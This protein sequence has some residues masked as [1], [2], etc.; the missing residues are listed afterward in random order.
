MR[1][2]KYCVIINILFFLI[3]C[4]SALIAFAFSNQQIAYAADDTKA[5]ISVIG[6]IVNQE[7]GEREL[8]IEGSILTATY[9]NGM[10]TYGEVNDSDAHPRYHLYYYLKSGK[11]TK[12]KILDKNDNEISVFIN[13]DNC[14][15]TYTKPGSVEVYND[16]YSITY[17][18]MTDSVNSEDNPNYFETTAGVIYLKEPTRTGYKFL[19]WYSDS[20]FSKYVYSINAANATSNYTLY[21]KWSEYITLP[22]LYTHTDHYS[23]TTDTVGYA[24]SY[25]NT[26]TYY[27]EG[28]DA[29]PNMVSGHSSYTAYN[30]SNTALDIKSIQG[31]LCTA[32]SY[33]T[34]SHIVI[35]ADE[36]YSV[37][38]ELNGGGLNDGE[39]LYNYYTTRAD[40]MSDPILPHYDGY[41]FL[42]WYLDSTLTKTVYSS[43]FT[44]S[45]ITFYAKWAKI[46]SITAY[47]S[48]TDFYTAT[49]EYVDTI[50]YYCDGYD[51]IYSDN[52]KDLPS[53]HEGYTYQIRDINNQIITH[54]S[55]DGK[56]RTPIQS[57]APSYIRYDT[58]DFYSITYSLGE[59]GSIDPSAPLYNYYTTREDLANNKNV[60]INDNYLFTGWYL[61]QD[62]TTTYYTSSFEPS[63]ITLYAKWNKK[64]F[65]PVYYY[66][67]SLDIPDYIEVGQ[68]YYYIDQYDEYVLGYLPDTTKQIPYYFNKYS[69]TSYKAYSSDNTEL[70]I[71]NLDG[72]LYAKETKDI[73]YIRIYKNYS[74]KYYVNG[75]YYFESRGAKDEVVKFP[76][77]IMG[78]IGK[79][80]DAAQIG[81]LSI[82]KE[83]ALYMMKGWSFTDSSDITW[84][85]KTEVEL[86]PESI[87]Y[88]DLSN[89]DFVINVYAYMTYYGKLNSINSDINYDEYIEATN[90][91]IT[92]GS[93][94]SLDDL[95]Q[96]HVTEISSDSQK[97]NIDKL[98]K[99]FKL[100]SLG[101][102][103]MNLLKKLFNGEIISFSDLWSSL[104]GKIL[105][106]AIALCTFAVI[107]INFVNLTKALRKIQS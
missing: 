18:N 75:Q 53:K 56:I 105:L 4:I 47:Y 93:L 28:L 59:G 68:T 7:T 92:N 55:L 33:G 61:D 34:P 5:K 22:V 95:M 90:G 106:I 43:S 86:L 64:Y 23:K 45:N 9:E 63:D 60:P 13:S 57:G 102:N 81:P 42:G 32:S 65:I 1:Y 94:H 14:Y 38:H 8:H 49:T 41:E 31:S 39:Q 30:T 3:A 11:Y 98:L 26:S 71:F 88:G 27:Y 66:D 79:N 50:S 96:E 24:Y 29:V 84:F 36:I 51:Y 80:Y 37:T 46:Y 10:W 6:Y 101:S 103:T 20:S 72:T 73:A 97:S 77:F 70:E 17:M 87:T 62:Y 91:I 48:Y 69:A 35:D 52:I 44:P 83:Y 21:A 107:L 54:Y 16:Y 40:L 67:S 78:F 2:K 25:F 19:G 100:D 85:N 58:P 15:A 89:K 74:V 82:G 12:F 76:D 104:L 99:Y